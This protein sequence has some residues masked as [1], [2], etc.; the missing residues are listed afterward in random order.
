M[1]R[2]RSAVAINPYELEAVLKWVDGFELSRCRKK[3]NRDFS[4][5]V[6]LAEILKFEFPHLVE[7]HNYNGCF[8]LQWKV[9]NWDILNRKVLRKLEMHLKSDEIEK[10]A[11]AE[12]NF[13]EEVLFRVMHQVRIMKSRNEKSELKVPEETSNVLT[14]KVWKS[15]GDQAEQVS[16]KVIQYSLFEELEEKCEQQEQKIRD[17]QETIID[18]QSALNSKTQIIEDLHQRLE[19][20]ERKAHPAMSM[21]SIKDSIQNLF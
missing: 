18:L 2:K 7:L 5:G 12:T 6:L 3:L 16:Q 20:K 14:I 10:L 9:Q 11:K 4:D 8:A 13:I 21:S 1:E 15:V 17:M 19:K